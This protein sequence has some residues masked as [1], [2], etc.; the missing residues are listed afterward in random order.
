M[1]NYDEEGRL[2]IPL[3]GMP[4]RCPQC[5]GISRYWKAKIR[6]YNAFECEHCGY[7]GAGGMFTSIHRERQPIYVQNR[8][9][10]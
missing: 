1:P 5:K 9:L 2:V 6:R 4:I 10:K 3:E 7:T 8:R